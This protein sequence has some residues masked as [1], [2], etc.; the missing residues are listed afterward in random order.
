M[1]ED[2]VSPIAQ[3]LVGT[4]YDQEVVDEV[5]NSLLETQNFISVDIFPSPVDPEKS[6]SILYIEVVEAL[7]LGTYQLKGNKLLTTD[8][9][10][11]DLPLQ[12]GN[13]FS[14]SSAENAISYIKDVYK[15]NGYDT[16][17]ISFTWDQNS[18]NSAINLTSLSL[19]TIGILINQLKGSPIKI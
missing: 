8:I 9:I 13:I 3:V 17:E 16:V 11:K 10:T 7:P 14:V 15:Q 6:Q 18:D 5:I 4:S 1:K 19:S 12:V 2:E